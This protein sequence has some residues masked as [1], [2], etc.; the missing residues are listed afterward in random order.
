MTAKYGIP[1][2]ANFIH[3]DMSPDDA[4]S[5]CCRLRLDNRELRKRGGGLFGSNP[6]TG[7]IGVVTIN[8]ARVGFLARTESEFFDR[9]FHLMDLAKESLEIKRKAL[10]KLTEAGLYPYSRFY[11]R[12]IKKAS[13]N[14]WNNHFN[15][16]GV[17]GMNEAL[18]NFHGHDLT[19]TE[20]IAS[21]PRS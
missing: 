4:R 10:E 14:Y 2:F 19:K 5:M 15:T 3:S 9:L 12:E 8:M 7:S 11:L 20:G 18:L 21:P 17:N 6:M 1:Y 16:I 13:G